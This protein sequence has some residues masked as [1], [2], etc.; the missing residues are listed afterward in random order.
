MSRANLI[1]A[2]DAIHTARPHL[3]AYQARHQEELVL[4]AIDA[5]RIH[6]AP[7]KHALTVGKYRFPEDEV[8]EPERTRWRDIMSSGISWALGATE[9]EIEDLW[10][11]RGCA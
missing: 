4:Q 5:V 8:R 7:V 11:E 2:F 10:R 9:R 6:H 1:A 3:T